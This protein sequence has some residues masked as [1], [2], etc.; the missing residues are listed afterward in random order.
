MAAKAAGS[1]PEENFQQAY[2]FQRK[3]QFIVDYS[4]SENSLGFHAPQYSVKILNE[5]TDYAR[6]GQLALRGVKVENQ[7]TPDSYNIKP[8][9]R[10]G[11]LE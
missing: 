8:V 6:S 2:Q 5:A 1:V 3:A 4:F 7:R 11:V 10:P 9:P